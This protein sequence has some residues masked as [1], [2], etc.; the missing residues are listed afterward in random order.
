VTSIRVKLLLILATFIGVSL[1]SIVTSIW[2]MRKSEDALATTLADRVIPLRDLKMI[3]DAYAVDIVDTSHKV[4][5]GTLTFAEGA[6]R[7]EASQK[8]IAERW[9][10]YMTTK[11]S[12]EEKA[13]AAVAESAASRSNAL[14]ADILGLL[15]ESN[16]GR[17]EMLL[18][19]R[20]Y[21]VIEPTTAAIDKLVGLQISETQRETAALGAAARVSGR[22]QR[23]AAVAVLLLALLSQIL[24]RRLV[25]APIGR[26][27]QRLERMGEGDLESPVEDMG[28]KDEVGRMAR[29]VDG[30]RASSRN[31]RAMEQ[32]KLE[33]ANTD[34][35]RSEELIDAIRAVSPVVLD[36]SRRV[37]KGAE[38]IAARAEGL[39]VAAEDTQ[40]RS[41]SA[42]ASLQGNTA[43]IQSMAAATSE[44][45]ISIQDVAGQGLRIVE[46][47]DGMANK[48]SSAD[49]EAVRLSAIAAR[50]GAA[51]DLITTVAEQTNLLALN[52][53]IEAARAGEAGRG[54]AVVAAEVKG[55]AGQAARASEEIRSLLGDMG[56]A[57]ASLRA[58][59]STIIGGVGDL[60]LVA[61]FVR[62]AVEEQSRSTEAISRS[63]EETAQVAGVI[64][65]DVAATSQ[66]AEETREAA[67]EASRV[68]ELL[69][70]ASSE[71]R[72]ALDVLERR[73]RAA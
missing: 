11:R 1:L 64:L 61:D 30:L 29:R 15:A 55:L 71:L 9:S 67:M 52:A 68:G 20:L 14:I 51:V 40:R 66:S 48:A 72:D 13:L 56:N 18:D 46:A 8:V 57:G 63:I 54:F 42:R 49:G 53:T 60:K 34:L 58:G 31:L 4:R 45:A 59:I 22:V 6:A 17:L 70:H 12:E 38:T 44:L 26:L 25:T 43:S 10:A 50:A 5:G 19:T 24:I 27:T 73:M 69:L 39:I 47:V 65:D 21:P 7:I 3:S 37:A 36:A 28:R 41:A 33:A 62:D 16:M 32:R 23:G 2:T 35:A